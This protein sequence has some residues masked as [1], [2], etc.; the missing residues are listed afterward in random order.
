M[1]KLTLLSIALTGALLSVPVMAVDFHALTGVQAISAPLQDAELSATEG[2]AVCSSSAATRFVGGAAL[3]LW[4]APKTPLGV[5]PEHNP[6]IIK[7]SLKGF[8]ILMVI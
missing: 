3:C 2:G 1:K 8:S 7:R 5:Q 4:L 6:L